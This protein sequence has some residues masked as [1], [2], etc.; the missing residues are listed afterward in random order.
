MSTSSPDGTGPPEP[1][2]CIP[3]QQDRTPLVLPSC[4]SQDEDLQ[5]LYAEYT[6]DG[7]VADAVLEILGHFDG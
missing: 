7:V 4:V 5:R 2:L 3:Y 6:A 1:L